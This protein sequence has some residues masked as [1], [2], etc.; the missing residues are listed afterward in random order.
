VG[1]S[2]VPQ[3]EHAGDLTPNLLLKF[4]VHLTSKTTSSLVDPHGPLFHRWLPDGEADAITLKGSPGST[5]KVWFDR[6]GFVEEGRGIGFIEYD[7]NKRDVDPSVMKRQSKLDAGPLSG[8]AEIEVTADELKAVIDDRKD[9]KDYLGLGK[10]VTN[11][12]I[13]PPVSKF[14]KTLRTHF[15]QY[16][17]SEFLPWDSRSISLGGFCASALSLRWSTDNG[18]TWQDFRPNES[19]YYATCYS[20]GD[21]SQ[22]ITRMTGTDSNPLLRTALNLLLLP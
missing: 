20:G 22:Y 2:F 13:G 7:Q 3:E 12:I 19:V 18:N 9:D 11:Q 16:W 14:I 6:R 1:V 4:V 17:I 10:R 15:G 8:V 21:F 5:I